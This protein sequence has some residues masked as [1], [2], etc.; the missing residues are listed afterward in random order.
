MKMKKSP[1]NIT[2]DD[3]HIFNSRGKK[4]DMSD[5]INA[6]GFADA[7]FIGESHGD[8]C[9][10]FLELNILENIYKCYQKDAKENASRPII[11]CMEMF[12]RDVQPV[13]DEY[14]NDM[15]TEKHFLSASRAWPGYMHNYRP[16]VEFAKEKKIPLIGANAPSRYANMVSRL[17]RDA[18]N[19]LSEHAKN[20]WLPPLP[21]K[22]SSEK[23]K[24]KF[25]KFWENI[26]AHSKINNN[27]QNDKVFENFIDA[28]S[29]WDA[30]M[31]FSIKKA[32][33]KNPTSLVLN[34]NGIFHSSQQLGTPEH[35]LNY[36]PKA[37][38]L[39][40]SII[41]GQNLPDFDNQYK[42]YGD[43]IIFTNPELQED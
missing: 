19:N 13:I 43:F 5:I 10:H 41:S 16:V 29:L 23:Y 2:S 32:L 24:E 3:Y 26:P 4:A 9:A 7:V 20:F 40:I 28:Q 21:Y 36:M 11:L 17:G 34:I 8:P 33:D 18:L 35:L 30:S 1:I 6:A 15:I 38:I 14:M 22:K 42:E 39:T 31:A 37:N 25:K 12:E 27:S